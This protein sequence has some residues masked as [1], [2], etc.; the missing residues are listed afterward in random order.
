MSGSLPELESV[1]QLMNRDLADML[2]R[3][4]AGLLGRN[5]SNFPGA[6]PVSFSRKHLWELK[7]KECV[8][9]RE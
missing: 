6:Q 8:Q 2:R 4:V 7:S 5:N 9:I 1:G 3:Q